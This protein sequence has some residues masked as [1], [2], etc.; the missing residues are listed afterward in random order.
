M[1]LRLPP[2]DYPPQDDM[3]EHMAAAREAQDNSLNSREMSV[4]ALGTPHSHT[5]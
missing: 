3:M 1:Y 4:F 5:V 2:I